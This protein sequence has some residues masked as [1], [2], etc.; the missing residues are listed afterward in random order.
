MIVERARDTVGRITLVDQDGTNNAALTGRMLYIA[1][2]NLGYGAA[3]T[4]VHAKKGESGAGRELCGC[5]G[6]EGM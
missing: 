5:G 6:V 1:L 2:R 3:F 4:Y